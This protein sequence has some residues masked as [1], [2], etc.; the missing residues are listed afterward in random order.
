M[1][2]GALGE[3]FHNRGRRSEEQIEVMRLL[4]T[5]ELVTYNGRWHRI[6]DAGINPLP[7]RRPIPVWIGGG[8]DPVLRRIARIGD[9]F[10]RS[11]RTPMV[12]PASRR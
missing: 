1:E 7:V 12:G 10:P 11:N 9:G 4:W 8:A 2:Y 6:T 3:D 5:N